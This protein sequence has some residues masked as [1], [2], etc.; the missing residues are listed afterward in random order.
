[1]C[2]KSPS[3]IR[4]WNSNPEPSDCESH[5]ITTRPGLPPISTIVLMKVLNILWLLYSY[6]RFYRTET[7]PTWHNDVDLHAHRDVLWPVINWL[8]HFVKFDLKL[9][10]LFVDWPPW[11]ALSCE[12]LMTTFCFKNSP[13]DGHKYW[14]LFDSTVVIFYVGKS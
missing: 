3:Y 9:I 11:N 8:V 14:A 4:C 12:N 5:P 7:L 6:F 13:F 2:E 1:M 10:C